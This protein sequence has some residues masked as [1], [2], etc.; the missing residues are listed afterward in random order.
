LEKLVAVN[1]YIDII[2]DKEIFNWVL[3]CINYKDPYPK[4]FQI[5]CAQIIRKVFE[6]REKTKYLALKNN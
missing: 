2:I 3:E 6:F 4:D 1:E 5:C